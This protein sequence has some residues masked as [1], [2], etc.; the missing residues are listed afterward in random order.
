MWREVELYTEKS[1]WG[2]RI[3]KGTNTFISV[4]YDREQFI[5]VLLAS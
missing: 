4:D 5:N 1:K 3:K 2:S